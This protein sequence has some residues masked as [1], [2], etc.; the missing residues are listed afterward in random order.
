MSAGRRLRALLTGREPVP[1]GF[2][3]TLE[4]DER[5]VADARG[6]R[7][8]IVLATDRGLWLPPAAS[9][10][11]SRRIPWHMVSRATW[12]S[13]ALEVVE[14]READDLGHGVV[15]LADA[16]PRRVPLIEP[17]RVPETVHRRVTDAIHSRH[18]HD[19]AD[20]GAWFVQR[21]VPGVGI[22]VHVRPDPG[23]DPESV[24][25]VAAG[26]GEKL[27]DARG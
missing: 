18:H 22:V 21:R 27:R 26:L 16:T 20:G 9:G 6:P 8:S 12:T 14:A 23:T 24:R 1:E 15:L 10:E 3:G 2:T 25:T 7:G 4:A 17:G 13:G 19:I 11:P 5:I